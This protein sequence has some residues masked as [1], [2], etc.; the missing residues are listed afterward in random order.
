MTIIITSNA[1]HLVSIHL[2]HSFKRGKSREKKLFFLLDFRHNIILSYHIYPIQ[3][4]A[5]FV[6]SF[7]EQ[8]SSN[9]GI[10]CRLRFFITTSIVYT[11]D[12]IHAHNIHK[13]TYIICDVHGLR[14]TNEKLKYFFALASKT[15]HV[16]KTNAYIHGKGKS[17]SSNNPSWLICTF[18]V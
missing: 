6:I 4:T 3:S 17:G 5:L 18:M 11:D 9:M 16:H 14:T 15:E 2:F 8:R 1:L 7:S 12:F 13:Y 10:Y